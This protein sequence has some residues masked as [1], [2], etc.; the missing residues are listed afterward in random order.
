MDSIL[1]RPEEII[2][3]RAES[4]VGGGGGCMDVGIVVRFGEME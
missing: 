1:E 3:E 4:G 2:L